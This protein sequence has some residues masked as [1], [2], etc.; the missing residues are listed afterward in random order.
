MVGPT[1]WWK[2]KPEPRHY[3][4]ITV[5]SWENNS[6]SLTKRITG[7][8]QEI[9]N[10]YYRMIGVINPN[11]REELGWRKWIHALLFK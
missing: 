4:D 7:E 2:I 3:L 11:N 8:K 5:R 10:T 1:T 6:V 9:C